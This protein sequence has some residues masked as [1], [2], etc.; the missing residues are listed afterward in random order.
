[1]DNHF[2]TATGAAIR[3]WQARLGVPAA[4]RT[5]TLA[6]GEV[7]FL[8]GPVRVSAVTATVGA[9]LAPDTP[10]LSATGTARV[11]S[12]AM[13]TDQAGLVHA[14][15]EVLVV[16]PGSGGQVPGRVARVGRVATAPS[17]DN[18]GP[19]G[20]ATVPVTVTLRIPPGVAGLDQAPVQVEITTAEHP[21]V[22]L[23]PVTALLA[24]PGGGY[25]VRLDSGR[26]VSVQPG[27][28]DDGTGTV[29]V[30]GDLTPGQRVAVPAS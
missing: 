27:L 17:S 9:R 3:R 26:Y 14:G 30:A 29:E 19:S 15:D 1:V 24:A 12:V 5:S 11:V 23:V 10:V 13:T 2:S 22:L 6:E 16:L 8:P 7:V 18:N 4:Q 25:Q 21:D 28:F 20:P